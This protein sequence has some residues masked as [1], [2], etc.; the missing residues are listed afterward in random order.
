MAG[1]WLHAVVK[2]VWLAFILCLA[3]CSKQNTPA[4]PR[5]PSDALEAKR[6]I[7]QQKIEEA[8]SKRARAKASM[9]IDEWLAEKLRTIASEEKRL[10]LAWEV[11]RTKQIL[12][13]FKGND[14]SKLPLEEF[15]NA[16]E[17][18]INN[19]VEEKPSDEIITQTYANYINWFAF[20]N[21]VPPHR[22]L[23][24]DYLLTREGLNLLQLDL[25]FYRIGVSRNQAI[26]KPIDYPQPKGKEVLIPLKG[27]IKKPKQ[28][29][30]LTE[31][32]QG[33]VKLCKTVVNEVWKD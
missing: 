27:G 13:I 8:E 7:A 31:E 17:Q 29:T 16:A 1:V 19:P 18:I 15:K 11:K 6:K 21:D 28:S 9:T 14:G 30:V 12:N 24:Y 33:F 20:R 3:S 26:G 10:E 5:A 22:A 23:R 32:E 4:S 25:L 2:P